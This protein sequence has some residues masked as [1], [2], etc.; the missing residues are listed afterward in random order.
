MERHGKLAE[1]LLRNGLAAPGDAVLVGVSGGADSVALLHLLTEI[2]PLLSLS[3]EVAHVEHGIRGARSREDAE[4]VRRMAAGLSLPFHLAQP[5]LQAAGTRE[6]EGPDAP[7]AAAGGAPARG[8][9]SSTADS[10]VAEAG[11][12]ETGAGEEAGAGEG[13]RAGNLEARARTERYRFFARVAAERRLNKVAVGHNGGDQVETMLMWLLRGCGPEG[14]AGMPATR[15][16]APDAAGR[17]GPLLIRPLL[18]VPRDELLEYLARRGLEYREDHTNRDTRYLRNWI[19]RTLLPGLRERTDAGLDHRLARLGRMLR[20]DNAL[21]EQ[22]LAEVYPRLDR[23]GVLDRTAFLRIEPELRSRMVRFW[24]RRVTGTLRRVGHAHVDA[25]LDLIAGSR[26]HARVSLPGAWTALR[27]YELIRLVSPVE[28][29]SAAAPRAT[30]VSANASTAPV[31]SPR[32]ARTP[33]T[34]DEAGSAQ[35]ESQ[36]RSDLGARTS[37]TAGEARGAEQAG[38]GY[39]CALPLEGEVLLPEAGLKVTAWRSDSLDLPASPF[40]A[41]FDVRAVERLEGALQVRNFRPGD[42]FRPLGMPGH[43]KL[44]DLFIEKKLPRSRRRVLPLVLAGGEIVWI[45]GCARGDFARLT[46]DSRSA[47][48]IRVCPFAPGDPRG[49]F[50]GRG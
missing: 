39:S 18:D 37:R 19:R 42:R 21:L 26:P 17:A 11:G 40:E 38:G 1:T 35:P 10:L 46:P 28:A 45:P 50:A 23:E 3:L 9:G 34:V 33:R 32:G 30:P 36:P 47:W 20:S 48:R 41:V 29:A 14:L 22:R 49:R 2:A 27:E 44:K 13:R 24:L 7:V 43:K 31:P 25:V 12:L 5:D 15:P 4:F 6:Q 16:L 8:G